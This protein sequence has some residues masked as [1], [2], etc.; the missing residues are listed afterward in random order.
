MKKFKIRKW[1]IFTEDKIDELPYI[2]DLTNENVNDTEIAYCIQ[3]QIY[4]DKI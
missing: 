1:Y 4:G 2:L 3:E